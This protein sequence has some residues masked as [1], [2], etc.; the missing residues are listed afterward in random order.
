MTG[1]VAAIYES[2]GKV[3][4]IKSTS[5]AQFIDNLP[6]LSVSGSRPRR[7]RLAGKAIVTKYPEAIRRVQA[8][9]DKA[10]EAVNRRM[11]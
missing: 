11:P 5:G 8:A 1:A 10:V 4:K 3:G 7:G 9:C 2:A 6:A